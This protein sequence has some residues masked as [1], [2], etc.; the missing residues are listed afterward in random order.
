MRVLYIFYIQYEVQYLK[1]IQNRLTD[2]KRGTTK[3]TRHTHT[4]ESPSKNTRG[5]GAT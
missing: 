3:K 5:S 1:N 2:K 4:H